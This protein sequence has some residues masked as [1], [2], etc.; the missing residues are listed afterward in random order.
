M[1]V[2]HSQPW[3]ST[4][5]PRSDQALENEAAG[6]TAEAVALLWRWGLT[7]NRGL[8]TLICQ[9][10]EQ[11]IEP[12]PAQILGHFRSHHPKMWKTIKTEHPNPQSE[13][14]RNLTG[15]SFAIPGRVRFQPNGGPPIPGI[16]VLRGYY[17]PIL[18]GGKMCG[19]SYYKTSSLYK[20]VITHP[21]RPNRPKEKDLSRYHC[22][23]Q[24]LFIGKLRK[25]FSVKTG[26][27]PT[28]DHSPNPYSVFIQKGV[29][30]IPG[31]FSKTREAL[32]T[33]ELPSLLRG[34]QW[35][36]FV[37]KYRGNPA[38]IVGLIKLP[39][40]PAED[41]A[42][43]KLPRVSKIWFDVIE[44][45]QKASTNRMVRVLVGYPP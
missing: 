27:D 12:K 26:L 40:P 25:I 6:L 24:T 37:E 5:S 1:S 41:S 29:L 39:S 42:L 14:E 11:A 21:T 18:E 44:A 33:E 35:H 28:N 2:P 13:L 30:P 36:L 15:Y 43:A 4:L 34:T 45:Y 22:D 31:I 7:V 17:C 9:T 3:R 32:K 38:D 8:R 10:C 20:H 19:A 16:K 23:C